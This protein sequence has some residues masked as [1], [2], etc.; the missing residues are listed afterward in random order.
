MQP[1]NQ[2]VRLPAI[3][4]I[5]EKLDTGTL[6]QLILPARTVEVT[7][8]RYAV[9]GVHG[10]LITPLGDLNEPILVIASNAIPPDD[11]NLVLGAR[12]I[13]RTEPPTFVSHWMKHPALTQK[14]QL[15]IDY[16]GRI[17]EVVES[18]RNA[19][20]YKEEDLERLVQGLRSP[21]AGAV[22]AAHA[23]WVTTHKAATIVMPTGTGKTETMLSLLVSKQCGKLLVVVP[24]DALRTQ[25]ADKFL[26]LGV[27]KSFGVISQDALHPIV[28]ILKHKPKDV[29]EVDAFFQ[30]CNVIVTTA[31]IAGQ[32]SDQAQARMAQ[33]CPFLFIDEAH[34]IAAATWHGFKQKFEAGKILQFTATPFRNDGKLVG[35]KIIFNYPLRKALEEEYFKKINFKPIIAYDRR[36]SDE[37]IAE[38]AV[39]QLREDR[40]QYDHI[41]MARV[42]SIERA[43]EVHAIYQ[44]Y[45]EFN[46]VQIHT[47]IKSKKERDRIR[48]MIITKEARIVVCVDMLGEGF[49]LPEL[50]IA[51]FHDIKKSLAITLQLAGRFTRARRDLG[52]PTF[53][54]NIGDVEVRDELRKLY[55]Q[56][57]DWNALL[58]RSSEEVI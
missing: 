55:I 48:Q 34:H 3:Y 21:Q 40:Q 20:S 51:A 23:H 12:R 27:L 22:H 56:D 26:T 18:W 25:I 17:R 52:D 7:E 57:A 4:A 44:R 6:R 41:V 36:E 35:G 53:I 28:G 38:K 31:H 24:S 15:P 50:K 46:P 39:E 54:A 30:R 1:P 14:P 2:T 19:F 10:R 9:A 43:N 13:G 16:S 5:D 8:E 58:T 11:F 29:D 42:E 32:C 49:D 37:A 33:H 45:P 47:G